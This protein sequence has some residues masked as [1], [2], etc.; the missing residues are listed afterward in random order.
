VQEQVSLLAMLRLLQLRQALVAVVL[1]VQHPRLLAVLLVA[2]Q[3]R[4]S[5]LI[6]GHLS[7]S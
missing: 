6:P 5:F 1:L 3:A 2:H 7:N 4:Q